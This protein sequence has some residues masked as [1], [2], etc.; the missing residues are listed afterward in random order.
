[1]PAPAAPFR[2]RAIV[3]L[4]FV[5]VAATMLAS[6][7]SASAVG[8]PPSSTVAA[9]A[10]QD[11]TGLPPVAFRINHA[12]NV[13][14][15]QIGDPYRYGAAGPGSFDCSGLSMYSYGHA[16]LSLPRTSADQYAAVRHILKKNMIRGDLVFFHS[17]GRI[18]HVGMFLYWNYE[19]RAVIVHSPSPGQRVHRSPVWTLS[20]YAGTRRP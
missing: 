11:G 3:A 2:L 15:A 9:Q 7:S 5:A 14:V 16:R 13:A 12:A 6:T 17:G 20:W 4:I 10:G 8:S 19:H 1:M 18:Y